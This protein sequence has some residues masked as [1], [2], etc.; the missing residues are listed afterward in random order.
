M[1]AVVLEGLFRRVLAN[2]RREV[3]FA[4]RAPRL[5]IRVGGAVQ[6]EISGFRISGTEGLSALSSSN[7]DSVN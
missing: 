7:R 5:M 6:A 4:V 2:V 1:I 3:Q